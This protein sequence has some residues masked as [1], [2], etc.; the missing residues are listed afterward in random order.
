MGL[1]AFPPSD[2]SLEVA[3]S[4]SAFAKFRRL[5]AKYEGFSLGEMEG[6]GGDRPWSSV[7]TSLGPLLNRPDDEY[8]DIPCADCMKMLPRLQQIVSLWER[9]DS[10]M[11]SAEH[12]ESGRELVS[13]LERCVSDGVPLMFA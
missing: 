4:Y 2:A 11:V 5:L 6:F 9:S 13:V 12:V 7:E 1:V 3:W 8:G 10:C